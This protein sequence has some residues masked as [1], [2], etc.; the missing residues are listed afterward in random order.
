MGSMPKG[1]RT[2]AKLTLRAT[3]LTAGA[4][5]GLASASQAAFAADTASAA[6][7]NAV[8][9]PG[10]LAPPDVVVG[11]ADG[12]VQLKVTLGA[13][14]TSTVTVNYSTQNGTTNSNTS[15]SGS[16]Y[17]YVGQSG[18]LTFNPG[19]TSQT[20]TVPLLNC[21]VSLTSGF[22]E[23][24]FNLF[25]N[26]SNSTIVRG[27]TQI[28]ITGDATASVKPSLYVRDATVDNTAGTINVPVLL[29]GP[30]GAALAAPVTVPYTTHDGT[31]VAGTDY[32]TTSGTLTFPAG[33][34]AQ[35]ISVPILNRT[36]AAPARS[37]SVTLGTP[38]TNAKI[39]D[40]T[41]IVTIGASG[42]TKIT[43][44]KISTGPNA[45]VSKADGYVDVPVTL[46]APG[47]NPVTVNYTTQ[48]GTTNS[49]SSCNGTTYSYLGQSGT[50]DFLPGVRTKTIR[51][52]LLNCSQTKKGTFLLNLFSNSSDSTIA[53][54]TTTIT[55][56]PTVTNPTAPQKVTAVAGNSS[57]KVSFTPPA[58]DGG[59]AINS[60]T[61]TSSPGGVTASGIASPI[62][63]NG[64]TNGTTYT[65]TVTA[66]NAHGTGP[67]SA[68]SN[69][70]TPS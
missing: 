53:R 41:G 17:G 12:S 42:G 36:G 54:G 57:A 59:S 65:F 4:V 13:A 69:P 47:L 51:I 68:P 7:V 3:A 21:G 2:A 64:L 15:C 6:A 27:S 18:T 55:V 39:A 5:L 60:Y 24:S 56:M 50:L 10:I 48:N 19:V 70:V 23:F 30:P 58:A 20:V 46:A 52:P 8:S 26:S 35:N 14:G 44:V 49:N 66:T 22:Q 67:A 34:T 61:V 25:S 38:T 9:M 40:G 33:E 63:V 32:T 28:D 31:A 11:A 1:R 16:T 37:F 43:T 62:T 45:E 29:G